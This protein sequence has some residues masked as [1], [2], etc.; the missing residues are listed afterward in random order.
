[1]MKHGV[2][3]DMPDR[4]EALEGCWEG[5][6][7]SV[8]ESAI[9][10]GAGFSEKIASIRFAKDRFI[11]QDC[12]GCGK[13][14]R[15]VYDTSKTAYKDCIQRCQAFMLTKPYILL[16]KGEEI[17]GIVAGNPGNKYQLNPIWRGLEEYRGW[18]IQELE[19]NLDDL[20][21]LERWFLASWEVDFE[22]GIV[23]QS[24]RAEEVWGLLKQR[25]SVR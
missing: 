2:S 16:E 6:Y 13:S 18:S 22:A 11:Y 25:V 24:R 19:R 9:M 12:S 14:H 15:E 3:S 21:C 23:P 20:L 4:E 17:P 8:Y 7:F 5:G 10:S 1:M